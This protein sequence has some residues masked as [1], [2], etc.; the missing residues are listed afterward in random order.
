[1]TANQA[2]ATGPLRVRRS[3]SFGASLLA[4]NVSMPVYLTA[5][6]SCGKGK[7]R[8]KRHALA[9]RM[10]AHEDDYLRFVATCG[11]RLGTAKPREPPGRASS[12]QGLEYVRSMAG[13]HELCAIRSCLAAAHHGISAL[14]ALTRLPGPALDLRN[15]VNTQAAERRPT[16]PETG[17]C[18]KLLPWRPSACRGAIPGR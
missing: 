13:A 11:S 7:L 12:D 8:E 1:M 15:R 10:Q 14:D 9:T 5:R 3:S 16:G 17:T 6:R 18:L 2:A 4:A